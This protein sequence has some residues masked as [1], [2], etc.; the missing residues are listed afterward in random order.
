MRKFSVKFNKEE[1]KELRA[2][3]HVAHSFHWK[4][5]AATAVSLLPSIVLLFLTKN[6]LVIASGLALVLL[7][8]IFILASLIKAA[9][10][11][12]NEP[13]IEFEYS[14]EYCR[15]TINHSSIEWKWSY[16]DELM[17]NDTRFILRKLDQHEMIPK[18]VVP[19]GDLEFLRDCLQKVGVPDSESSSPVPMFGLIESSN[20][21]EV[22]EFQYETDD[23]LKIGTTWSDINSKPKPVKQKSSVL[24]VTIWLAIAIA[25]GFLFLQSGTRFKNGA[26]SGLD[27]TQLFMVVMAIA[28][29][30]F[31][32]AL[33]LKISKRFSKPHVPEVPTASTR[34]V[35]QRNGWAVGQPDN[36]HLHEWRDIATIYDNETC[37]GFK[38]KINRLIVLPKRIFRDSEH[39]KQFIQATN[40]LYLAHCR[41]FEMPVAAIETG[42]PYQPPSSS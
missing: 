12:P 15:Q 10:P 29:P 20:Q 1:L 24:S 39:Q 31:I 27:S 25:M 40:E 3:N 41:S 42:N 28:L 23:I 33:L 4:S 36:M 32:L 2:L 30:F 8:V 14:N 35:M 5:L 26:K 34:F 9:R 13:T 37:F 38:T 21:D 22:F 6:Y 16:Y 18:R 17:E 19:P 11:N 7:L